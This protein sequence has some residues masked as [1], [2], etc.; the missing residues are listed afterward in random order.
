MNLSTAILSVFPPWPS[1]HT[2]MTNSLLISRAA[3][4]RLLICGEIIA[5]WVRL[6][7]GSDIVASSV[8]RKL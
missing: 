8:V 3:L 1:H 7:G 4:P 5:N 2:P 6:S